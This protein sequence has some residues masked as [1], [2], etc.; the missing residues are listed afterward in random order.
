MALSFSTVQVAYKIFNRMKRECLPTLSI[1]SWPEDMSE[2]DKKDKDNP[3]ALVVTGWDKKYDNGWENL[4]FFI[5][6]PSNDIIKKFEEYNTITSNTS[7]CE[8]YKE[9]SD[10]WIFG[11]F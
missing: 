7:M 10:L 9:G 8:R 5:K 6:N 11:W 4:F 2:W 1:P 3:P